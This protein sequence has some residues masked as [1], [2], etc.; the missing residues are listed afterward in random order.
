MALE[1]HP[2]DAFWEL[3]DLV[4]TRGLIERRAVPTV[5]KEEVRA[6]YD[7]WGR[8]CDNIDPDRQTMMPR[9]PPWDQILYRIET[10]PA[11]LSQA[12][13]PPTD[14]AA[15]APNLALLPPLPP[16]VNVFAFSSIQ[17]AARL[18]DNGRSINDVAKESVFNLHDASRLHRMLARGF[19]RINEG[20]LLTPDWRVGRRGKKY[21]LRFFDEAAGKW[22]DPARAG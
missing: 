10:V 12:P 20:K 7:R 22:V 1:P 9:P 14:V 15:A 5:D 3:L 6:A 16:D 19:F 2:R 4:C 17:K 8:Y 21:A 13:D 18:F 11:P